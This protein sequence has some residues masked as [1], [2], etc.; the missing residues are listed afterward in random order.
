[1]SLW[2]VMAFVLLILCT[3]M[4]VGLVALRI[5][6]F[7]ILLSMNHCISSDPAKPG[8]SQFHKLFRNLH[9]IKC[10]NNCFSRISYKLRMKTFQELCNS[11]K[12]SPCDKNWRY[13]GD[14]CYGFFKHNLTWEESKQYCSGVN[15][16]LPKIASQNI[17]DCLAR[18]LMESGCGKMAQLAQFS[19]K[20]CKS[21]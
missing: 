20:I 10:Q 8:S 1:S 19:P 11:H 2:R 21:L 12:C 7:K 16:T 17:L 15:A 18:T 5:M 9:L 4:V 3:G 13:Y 14:S 6:S